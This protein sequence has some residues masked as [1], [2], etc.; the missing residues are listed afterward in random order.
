MAFRNKLDVDTYRN[1]NSKYLRIR[2]YDDNFAFT[3]ILYNPINRTWFEEFH[4]DVKNDCPSKLE[5]DSNIRMKWHKNYYFVIK[6]GEGM[7]IELDRDDAF[8]FL[9]QVET[10]LSHLEN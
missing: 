1:I 3:W 6:I 2:Y 7:T 4:S 9:A 8:A 10:Y 5:I